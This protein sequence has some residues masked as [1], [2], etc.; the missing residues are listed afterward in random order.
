MQCRLNEH[1]KIVIE[2][3]KSLTECQGYGEI[4]I[5]IRAG[6]ICSVR[7]TTSENINLD[8]PQREEP[9]DV[10]ECKIIPS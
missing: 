2:R 8:V 9:G 5:V 10:Q 7:K 6:S 3:I 4:V 1:E